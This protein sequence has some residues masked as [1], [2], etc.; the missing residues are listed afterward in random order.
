MCL[1]HLPIG[2]IVLFVPLVY[3]DFGGGGGC[4]YPLTLYP[5]PEIT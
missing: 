3:P 4:K 1:R 5:T 2:A